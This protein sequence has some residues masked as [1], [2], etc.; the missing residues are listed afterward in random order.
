MKNLLSLLL[1]CCTVSAC[2]GSRKTAGTQQSTCPTTGVPAVHFYGVKFPGAESRLANVPKKYASYTVDSVEWKAFAMKVMERGPGEVTG[3]NIPLPGGCK[4]FSVTVSSTMSP[5]LA[6]KYP[7]LASLKGSAQDGSD[8]RLDWNGT[9]MRGQ[10][11][12]GGDTYF[13]EPFVTNGATFYLVYHKADAVT[14]KKP[15]E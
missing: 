15:F 9:A 3:L 11:I 12:N 10:V 2:T 1:L 8:L 5:E 13:L 14:T 7:Q 6:A 4:A